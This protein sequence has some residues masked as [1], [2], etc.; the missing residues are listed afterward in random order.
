MTDGHTG[1]KLEHQGNS[2]RGNEKDYI[3]PIFDEALNE[4]YQSERFCR[5]EKVVVLLKGLHL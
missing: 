4:Q 2:E 5:R 1:L 3:L